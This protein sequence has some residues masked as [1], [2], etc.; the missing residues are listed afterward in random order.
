MDNFQHFSVEYKD[1]EKEE[2]NVTRHSNDYWFKGEELYIYA[3]ILQL[4][5][6]VWIS[7]FLHSNWCRSVRICSST[8]R[9]I[10]FV[11]SLSLGVIIL[12]WK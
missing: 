10:A 8:I 4:Q 3:R 2:E 12:E 7:Y 1:W 11:I 9:E 5:I 6:K